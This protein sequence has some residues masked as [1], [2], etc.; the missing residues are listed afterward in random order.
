MLGKPIGSS[1][2]TQYKKVM[3]F[4]RICVEI[5][6]SKPLPD[7]VEVSVGSYTWVQQL[8]YETLPFWCRL[9]NEYG[10]LQC[11]YPR[12]KPVVPQPSQPSRN[13]PRTDNGK[14]PIPGDGNGDDGYVPVKAR[15]RNRGQKRTLR[16][17]QDDETFNRFEVLDDLS[18]EEVNLGLLNLD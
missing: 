6:L 2:Q 12:A 3:T 4:A 14:E 17:R 16:E 7:S 9:C 8:D 11:R 10:H 18:Q 15:N 5:D 13:P 1:Q